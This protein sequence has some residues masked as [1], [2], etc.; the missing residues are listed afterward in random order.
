MIRATASRLPRRHRRGLGLFEVLLAVAVLTGIGTVAAQVYSSGLERRITT[1]EARALDDLARA[2]RLWLEGDPAGRAPTGTAPTAVT[3][4]TLE[5]AGLRAPTDPEA[6][7]GR[8][9]AMTVWLWRDPL[10]PTER[11]LVIARARGP[12]IPDGLPGAETGV[13]GVG[14]IRNVAGQTLVIGPALTFET[15]PLNTALPGFAAP[16]DLFVLEQVWTARDCGAYL[17]RAAQAGCPDANRMAADLDLGGF[18]L[19]GVR[20]L[21]VTGTASFG[22]DLDITGNATVLGTATVQ[23]RM[24]A[25]EIDAST[26][27]DVSG[28]LVVDGVLS[29][30][31]ANVSGSLVVQTLTVGGC[32]GC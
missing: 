24:E 28:G 15:T 17:H 8:R 27:L 6:T 32:T 7:P 18:D 16:G 21:T 19:T 9:R 2:G 11:V 13:A 31:T 5:T 25:A 4:A 10:G 26:R 22:G 14:A 12:V 3:T 20:E 30:D 23:G 29:A 1:G